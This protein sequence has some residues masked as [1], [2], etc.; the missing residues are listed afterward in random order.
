MAVKLWLIK[1]MHLNITKRRNINVVLM[2]STTSDR[3]DR[4]SREDFYDTKSDREW[5]RMMDVIT[6]KG[7]NTSV[8]CLYFYSDTDCILYMLFLYVLVWLSVIFS[9]YILQHL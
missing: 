7:L 6:S 5:F 9:R 8:S 3:D 4:V 1:K 2:S